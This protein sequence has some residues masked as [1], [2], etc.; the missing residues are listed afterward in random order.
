MQSVPVNASDGMMGR[1]EQA[2][3]SFPNQ[4]FWIE[5]SRYL[6][7]QQNLAARDHFFALC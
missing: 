1:L 7:D 3:F 6:K 2:G 5:Y 4:N